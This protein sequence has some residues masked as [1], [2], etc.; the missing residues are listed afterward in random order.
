MPPAHASAPSPAPQDSSQAA[1]ACKVKPLRTRGREGSASTLWVSTWCGGLAEAWLCHCLAVTCHL[2]GARIAC[3]QG[4][5]SR[6]GAQG[7]PVTGRARNPHLW[8]TLG[9][10]LAFG[11]SLFMEHE[12]GWGGTAVDTSLSLGAGVRTKEIEV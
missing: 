9:Q 11:L 12:A 8:A 3:V 6:G 2:Q 1:R 4:E 10:H 7:R 5:T